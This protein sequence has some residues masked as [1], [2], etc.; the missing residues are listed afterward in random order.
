MTNEERKALLK[1]MSF[2]I[3]LCSSMKPERKAEVALEAIER[4]YNL[5]KKG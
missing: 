3:G 4:R 2:T 1:E 5:E